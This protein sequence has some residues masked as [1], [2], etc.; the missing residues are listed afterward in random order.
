M[1]QKVRYLIAGIKT[2][3]LDSVKTG[4]MSDAALRTDFEAYVTLYK[5]FIK[6]STALQNPTI[7]ISAT[8]VSK[9]RKSVSFEMD[10]DDVEVE[11]RY[12]S[13]KEYSKLSSDQKAKLKALR[14]AR[15]GK[16]KKRQKKDPTTSTMKKMTKQISALTAAI[17]SSMGI[18]TE[19]QDDNSSG[20]DT[21][22][23]GNRNNSA[24]T[25]QGAGNGR[26]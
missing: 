20:I 12:Y 8:T 21:A 1:V 25:R 9:K 13:N 16:G 23:G 24:L 3:A 6:Q 10:Q 2:S 7:G 22:T 26:G 5:D 17:A 11:D 15:G 19:G 4:I 18:A 14:E